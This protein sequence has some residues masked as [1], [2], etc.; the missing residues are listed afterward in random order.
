MGG[1]CCIQRKDHADSVVLRERKE[2]Y[3]SMI[4]RESLAAMKVRALKAEARALG[5]SDEEI[6]ACDDSHNPKEE[7][8]E[9]ML[10][11]R[12]P[13][14]DT[15]EDESIV[16]QLTQPGNGKAKE[17]S[18]SLDSG[19]TMQSEFYEP[20][21]SGTSFTSIQGET[22]PCCKADIS[23]SQD[24]EI[25]V[26][27]QLGAIGISHK[28]DVITEVEKDSQAARLGLEHGW[29]II[30]VGDQECKNFRDEVFKKARMGTKP[31]KITFLKATAVRPGDRVLSLVEEPSWKPLPLQ[32]GDKG[33]VI[34]LKDKAKYHIYFDKGVKG[35]LWRHGFELIEEGS[36]EG[37]VR[38]ISK[39]TTLSFS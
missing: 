5:K 20:S 33:K 36:D 39:S 37:I 29:R 15:R 26:E 13:V 35:W 18:P 24:A 16:S 30:R 21:I 9:L 4:Y 3:A 27:F 1:V 10:S 22:D 6:D 2:T 28:Q 32:K 31:Y 23:C 7:L 8:I 17:D 38:S 19:T 11:A 25:T 12:F 34:E 14:A